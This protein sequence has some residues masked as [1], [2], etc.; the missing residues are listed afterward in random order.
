M[1]KER[2]GLSYREFG[3]IACFARA[4]ALAWNRSVPLQGERHA[5]HRECWFKCLAAVFCQWEATLVPRLPTS[6]C[7]PTPLSVLIFLSACVQVSPIAAEQDFGYQLTL[8]ASEKMLLDPA[9]P[10][11]AM[12]AAWQL[13][14]DLGMARS[15]PWLEITNTSQSAQL[16]RFELSIGDPAFHFA[17][18]LELVGPAGGSQSAALIQDGN[19]LQL[20]FSDFDPGETVRV[21][22]VLRPD[23]SQ[24]FQY[25]DF[26]TVHFDVNG[27]DPSDNATTLATFTDPGSGQEHS[28][29]GQ[30]DD[31][32]VEGP[33]FIAPHV[34]RYRDMDHLHLFS[35]E[36]QGSGA[37]DDGAADDGDGA[38]D[39]EPPPVVP[40]PAGVTLLLLGIAS[41]GLIAHWL[42][43][44]R[45]DA[46]GKEAA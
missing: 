27:D 43:L 22:F 39:G 10:V 5:P 41:L 3:R 37:A 25:P 45:T 42:Q 26:R 24:V 44:H 15:R 33:I 9:N 4:L 40:E 7:A 34:R 11:T 29:T 1:E 14:G 12:L 38:D 30:L 18:T 36:D 46:A 21:Q 2:A 28:L 13:Q 16:T 19:V 8:A 32:Q 6:L 35:M 31:F 23:S 20:D 17:D